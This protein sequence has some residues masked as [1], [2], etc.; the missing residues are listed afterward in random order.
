MAVA[1]PKLDD[2]G[3]HFQKLIQVFQQGG[4]KSATVVR[5]EVPCCGGLSGMAAEAAKESG[6]N[7]PL[8]EVIIGRDGSIVGRQPLHAAA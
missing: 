1:C 8:T 3:A 6:T 4:L 7:I 5:M 2:A